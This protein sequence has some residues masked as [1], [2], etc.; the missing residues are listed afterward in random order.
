MIL[1]QINTILF[2]V[3]CIILTTE[4][5]IGKRDKSTFVRWDVRSVLSTCKVG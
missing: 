5:K 3:I 1:Y 2:L 4:G